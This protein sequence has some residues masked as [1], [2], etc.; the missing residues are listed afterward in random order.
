MDA[1]LESITPGPSPRA[2]VAVE[3]GDGSVFTMPRGL[4]LVASRDLV[5]ALRDLEVA[6]VFWSRQVGRA[7]DSLAKLDD[8]LAKYNWERAD[9]DRSVVGLLALKRRLT[10]L[11]ARSRN[12]FGGWDAPEEL[13][14]E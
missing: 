11:A 14:F 3:P 8:V 12:D 6:A 4:L 13:P 5:P 2:T 1:T 7:A 10:L 9:F